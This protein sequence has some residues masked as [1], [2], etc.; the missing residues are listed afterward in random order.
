MVAW[1]LSA[2][3]EGTRELAISY[4]PSE[5]HI[6]KWRLDPEHVRAQEL[7]KKKW[8]KSFKVE[9]ADIRSQYGSVE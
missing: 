8:Y 5:A 7:G 9:I 3:T 6:G 4:W 2:S 1:T